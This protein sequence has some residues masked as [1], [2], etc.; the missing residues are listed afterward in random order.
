M[1]VLSLRR[2]TAVGA[3]LL[4]LLLLF[5]G[6]GNGPSGDEHAGGKRKGEVLVFAAASLTDL[7]TAAAAAFERENGD[8]RI[9]CNFAGSPSLATQIAEGAPADLFAPASPRFV[10][11]AAA[12]GAVVRSSRFAR[13]RLV[14]ITPSG[15][16]GVVKT[17][18]DV[19]RPG[20]RL[21]LAGPGVPAGEY[22]RE[23]LRRAGLLGGAGK[24]IVSDEPDV[25]SVLGKILSGAG[26]AGI[27]Y[28]TDVAGVA[29]RDV[30]VT[31]IPDR[32]NVDAVY[33]LALLRSGRNR[34]GAERFFAFLLSGGAD[35]LID[36][37]H[38]ER[39]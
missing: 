37:L 31:E 38:F 5:G 17:F 34:E 3:F 20:V 30:R 21:V 13:S 22:A 32:Y 24:N 33:E 29:A 7:F 25:R 4:P 2:R 11:A 28:A 27:V 8:L 9:V 26:D 19:A 15:G 12:A 23:S 39:F 10:E 36:S 14:L 1:R 18:R 6:C 16:K 35:G